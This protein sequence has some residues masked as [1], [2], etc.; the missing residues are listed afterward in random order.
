MR[1]LILQ[2]DG[3]SRIQL[4]PYDRPQFPKSTAELTLIFFAIC[5]YFMRF[6]YVLG[7]GLHAM[8]TVKY[9]NVLPT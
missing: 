2:Q 9:E 3:A 6:V 4:S 8:T 5:V 1:R 7:Y